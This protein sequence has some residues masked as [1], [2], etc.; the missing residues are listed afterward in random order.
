M[1]KSILGVMVLALVILFPFS[2]KADTYWTAS[3]SDI[4]TT[5]S[6]NV[7]IGTTTPNHSLEVSVTSNSAISSP[8][9]V[10]NPGTYAAGWGAG[11]TFGGT[12]TDTVRIRETYVGADEVG[13]A[14]DVYSAG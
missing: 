3:G 11:L 6:G 12:S 9:R 1:Q 8:V 5:N 7:G 14:F 10:S 13:L 4:Y 2:A